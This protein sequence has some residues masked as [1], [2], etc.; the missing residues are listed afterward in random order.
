[1]VGA[2]QAQSHV[3]HGIANVPV[4]HG[5]VDGE[6]I[7]AHVQTLLHE[8]VQVVKPHVAGIRVVHGSQGIQ[9]RQQPGVGGGHGRTE[10]RLAALGRGIVDV[11]PPLVDLL[12]LLL[13]PVRLLLRQVPP[14]VPA[15]QRRAAGQPRGNGGPAV[16]QRA[17]ALGQHSILL[18][19]PAEKT[20][21]RRGA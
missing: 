5:P 3:G 15:R 10:R 8:R 20:L 12:S 7:G 9:V 13:S 1:M 17:H 11:V 14:S 4:S 18:F 2:A 16:P 6:Q 21:L 19:G